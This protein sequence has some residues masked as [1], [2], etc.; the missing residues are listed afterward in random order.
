MATNNIFQDKLT[1]L[2]SE[3]ER[4]NSVI[5]ATLD[6]WLADIENGIEEINSSVTEPK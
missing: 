1:E 6:E 3:L 4:T 2:I 5:D